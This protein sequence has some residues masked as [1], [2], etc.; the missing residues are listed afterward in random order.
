MCKEN[1]NGILT[2]NLRLP[3]WVQNSKYN[4]RNANIAVPRNPAFPA[5]KFSRIL[6]RKGLA[7]YPLILTAI[8][9]NL[10]IAIPYIHM[11]PPYKRDYN[12]NYS[13]K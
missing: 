1:I 5:S 10:T 9:N 6:L 8:N 12:E 2:P 7:G 11:K 13:K 4:E 3:F